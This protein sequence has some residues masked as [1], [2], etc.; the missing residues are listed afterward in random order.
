MTNKEQLTADGCALRMLLG[1]A[2][3]VT[4][5]SLAAFGSWMIAKI[6]S[7]DSNRGGEGQA[8]ARPS[9]IA[10][11]FGVKRAQVNAWLARLVEA[12]KVRRWQPE[13][14]RGTAGDT[15]YNIEDIEKAWEIQK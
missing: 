4:P 6:K 3:V 2:P 8:W 12:G 7:L 15:Y 14:A 10:E 13:T 9:Q 1:D 11:R 5:D